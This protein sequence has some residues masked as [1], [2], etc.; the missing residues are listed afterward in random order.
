M[1]AHG[2]QGGYHWDPRVGAIGI[3]GMG[4]IGIPWVGP[5]APRCPPRGDRGALGPQWGFKGLVQGAAQILRFFPL[6][7][8]IA[9]AL[10]QVSMNYFVIYVFKHGFVF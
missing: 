7:F 1:G 6:S 3:P 4:A 5:L 10:V 9:C 8:N 2:D